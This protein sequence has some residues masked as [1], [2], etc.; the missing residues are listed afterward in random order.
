MN[1]GMPAGPA[2]AFVGEVAID[3]TLYKSSGAF[4]ID[5]RLDPENKYLVHSFAES[6]DMKNIYDGVVVTDGR[7]AAIV[8][9]PDWFESLNRDFRYQL[10]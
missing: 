1:P 5:H 4:K 10:R 7:G 2:G 8:T 3:G 9:L 6:P